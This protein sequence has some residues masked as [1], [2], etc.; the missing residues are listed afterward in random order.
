MNSCGV[1][2]ESTENEKP[3]GPFAQLITVGSFNVAE[4]AAALT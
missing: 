2:L 4:R 1:V 3:P